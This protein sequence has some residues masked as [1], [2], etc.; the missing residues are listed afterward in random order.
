M[1]KLQNCTKSN[2]LIMWFSAHLSCRLK[3]CSI[4]SQRVFYPKGYFT[5]QFFSTS[6]G[7][8]DSRREKDPT[9]KLTFKAFQN[10]KTLK[11]NTVIIESIDVKKLAVSFC[12]YR[13]RLIASCIL[14]KRISFLEGNLMNPHFIFLIKYCSPIMHSN[15]FLFLLFAANIGH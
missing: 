14:P 6:G 5:Q 9:L 4:L 7:K 15:L 1:S 8:Q 10:G 3:C 2:C 12:Y 11:D 13:K